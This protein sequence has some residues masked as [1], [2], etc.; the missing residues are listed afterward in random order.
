MYKRQPKSGG[1]AK[2][3]PP[4]RQLHSRE[5]GAATRGDEPL[6]SVAPRVPSAAANPAASADGAP[7]AATAEPGAAALG[8]AAPPP[9]PLATAPPVTSVRIVHSP[10]GERA[11]AARADAADAPRAA[12]DGPERLPRV[13][14]ARDDVPSPL[15][16]F[17]DGLAVQGG[18]LPP[19]HRKAAAHAAGPARKGAAPAARGGGLKRGG[20]DALRRSAGSAGDDMSSMTRS[21]TLV[22]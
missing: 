22:R 9:R 17:A 4:Q 7:S 3:G 6:L 18:G 1:A 10:E 19:R 5:A 16:G 14:P 15:G 11:A 21:R 13:A 20:P 12:R 8:A 2:P